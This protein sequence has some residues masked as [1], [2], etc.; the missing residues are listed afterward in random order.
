MSEWEFEPPP[1]IADREVGLAAVLNKIR[2]DLTA[3]QAKLSEA[4]RMVAT[5]DLGEAGER[6][7]CPTC[8]AKLQGPVTLAEHIRNSHGG[9]LP[10]HWLAIEA[11]S[12]EPDEAA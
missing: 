8:G 9:P 10:E 3:C 4:M 11:R 7:P 12:L 1:G 5:L 2:Y 6:I